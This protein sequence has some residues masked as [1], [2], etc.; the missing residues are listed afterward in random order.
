MRFKEKRMKLSKLFCSAVASALIFTTGASC[1]LF[2]S[3]KK[4]SG[5]STETQNNWNGPNGMMPPDGFEPPADW[6]PPEGMPGAMSSITESHY[7]INPTTRNIAELDNAAAPSCK[8]SATINLSAGTATSSSDDITVTCDSS[9][10]LITIDSSNMTDNINIMVSGNATAP[11]G[12]YIKPNKKSTVVITLN[13]ATFTSGDYPCINVDGKSTVYLTS[14][15]GSTNTLTDSRQYGTSY[16]T[17]TKGSVYAKGAMVL[18]GSGSVTLNESYKHGFYAKDYI[19]VFNGSWTVNSTGRNGFQ[20]VN[21]FIMD[22]GNVTVNGTGTHT[23]NESRGIIVEGAE[24]T[25]TPGEG[26]I[27][28]NGGTVVIDTYSKGISAKWD[29]DEDR[30]TEDTSDDPFPIV[31]INGGNVSVTT[32]GRPMDETA[33]SYDILNADGGYDNEPKK[34]S[35]EGI[36]GKQ[37]VEI[38][39][40]TLVLTTTDD[41]INASTADTDAASWVTITGGRI[42]CNSS[43]NDA[44]DSNGFISI[45]GGVIVAQGLAMPECAFD[46]DQNKFEITGGLVVGLGTG[47][48]SSPTATYCK[49]QGSLVLNG[50][51]LGRDGSTMAIKNSNGNVVFAFTLPAGINTN[52]MTAVISSPDLLLGDTY[53][54]YTGVTAKNGENWNGLY[55]TLPKVSGGSKSATAAN[56]SVTEE[57][58]VGGTITGGFGFGGGMRG[59]FDGGRGRFDGNRPEDFNGKPDNRK[60]R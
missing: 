45:S 27:E 58:P 29:I 25:S 6:T 40:G 1:T 16:T 39:G 7:I 50:S 13:N 3:G 46:C 42:Y 56:M 36:E 47:N 33:Q 51:D 19:H 21:A 55:T 49:N 22:G 41:C 4:D 23:N 28:I 38:N 18:T 15:A 44:I 26:F 9:T 59:G 30:E 12:L 17:T 57:S 14:T 20:S 32:H 53:T 8:A 34:L 11:T 35:P 60:G 37:A 43:S 24:S 10:G 52:S 54:V 2:A 5:T 48:F 31:R